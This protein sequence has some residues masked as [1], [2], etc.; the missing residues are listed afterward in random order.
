LRGALWILTIFQVLYF[1]IPV[2]FFV[3]RGGGVT[4]P[5]TGFPSCHLIFHPS[6]TGLHYVGLLTSRM[7]CKH[8]KIRKILALRWIFVYLIVAYIHFGNSYI[9][10]RMDSHVRAII[11]KRSRTNRWYF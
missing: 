10:P 8:F 7:N 1:T 11:V 6:C 3:G 9:H 5:E 4:L 2:Y